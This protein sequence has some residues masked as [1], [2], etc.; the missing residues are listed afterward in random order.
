MANLV[1]CLN[2]LSTW[3]MVGL[4]WMVQCVHYP[5]FAKVSAENYVAYQQ[6]HERYITPV[7]GVPMLIEIV[8][9][10]LLL[11]FVPKGVPVAWVWTALILLIVAWLST[12]F[13]QVP[14]HSKLNIAFDDVVHRRL[15]NTNWI[16]TVSW[17]ARGILVAWFVFGSRT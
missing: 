5:L 12:A 11:N 8:T 3:Y 15:V 9:A 16:R 13:L 17:T 10:M 14:C 4:I 2:L 1:L 7:V 6:L